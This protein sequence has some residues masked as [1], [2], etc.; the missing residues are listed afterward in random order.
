M[1][2]VTT[3]SSAQVNVLTAS[4][5]V[6]RT[7]ANLL[8]TQLTPG[9]V[10][11]G[12]FGA[13][14]IFPVDGEVFA[15]PLY[16]SNVTIGAATHNVVLVATEHNTVYA[17]DADQTSPPVLLWSV[18]L[19]PSVP[20][21]M[22]TGSLGTYYDVSPE[23]GIL[24]TGVVDAVHGVLYVVAET[25]QNGTIVF[26][27]HALD[28]ATGG[29]RMNGPAAITASVAMNGQTGSSAANL[30]FDP[31]QHIQRPGLLLLNGAV[32]VGFGSHGDG[33]VWHGWLIRYSASDLTQQLGVFET[34]PTGSG[35]AIWESG[36][37]PVADD[38]GNIYLITG[39]GDYDGKQDF[40]ESFVKLSANSFGLA[41]WYTPANWQTLSDND[42][43]LSAG[44]ALVPG[45]HLLVGG[46]KSGNLYLVNGDSMGHLDSG[47]ATQVFAAVDGFIFTFALWGRP[48]ATYVYVREDDG[49]VYCFRLAGG[50][51]DTTPISVSTA[52]GGAARVSMA[53]SANAGRDGTGILWMT[54]GGYQ[55]PSAPGVLHAFDAANLANELWNSAMV[56][57]DNLNGFIKFVSPTVANGRVYM[58]SSASV[59]VYGLLSPSAGSQAPPAIAAVTNGA[60][61]NPAG[62][63]PGEVITIFGSNLGPAGGVGLQLDAFGNVSALLSATQVQFDG[64]PAPVVYVSA[65]QVSAIVPFG[66]ASPAAQLQVLYQGRPSNVVPETVQPTA[67]GLFTADASGAG[68]ALAANPD[69]TPNGSQNPA[70]A[71]S[72][73]VLYATGFGQTSPVIPEGSVVTASA[74]PQP[75]ASVTAQIGGQPATVLYA[76][77]APGLAA[78]I[79]QVNVAIP[80]GV[81]AGSALPVTLSV[82]DQASQS[83]V[84]IAVR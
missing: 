22:L 77:G 37:G 28:V 60:S 19:G 69:Y 15:Q 25:L 57:Q 4:Y 38:A 34:T 66:V 14:C 40:S 24:G 30:V 73:I 62:I 47:N 42:Y 58:A 6:E 64:I 17:Y 11:P 23:V 33:G 83:G 12:I 7:N 52:T 67:P 55:D 45:T 80:N 2:A 18:N 49:S 76:G 65:N 68:Q 50:A 20:S 53:L 16:V 8:E 41:D 82:G 79:M 39:N 70:A 56:P 10:A 72:Y 46:D 21:A 27:L 51:F 59:V 43:D 13:L 32:S 78:G 61:Y 29:E 5:G 81:A 36:R 63:S 26:Q 71:G 48:D 35:G 1:M 74:L 84:T 75:V 54:S 44:P 9:N 31:V 3:V